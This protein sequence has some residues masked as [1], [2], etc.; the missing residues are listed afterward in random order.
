ML[1]SLRHDESKSSTII[2]KVDEDGVYGLRED[3]AALVIVNCGLDFLL[4]SFRF[5]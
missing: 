4:R 2:S 3:L 1:I 5:D